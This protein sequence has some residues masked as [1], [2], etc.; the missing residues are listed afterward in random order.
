[1]YVILGFII[2]F[3]AHVSS[4]LEDS[5][6]KTLEVAHSG[7]KLQK[8]RLK[9]AAENLANEDSTG[10]T[11]DEKPY[12]RKVLF[13]KNKYN[14]R[15]NTNVVTIQRYDVSKAPLK[16]RY[17]P[18]HPAADK[19][20]YVAYPNVERAVEL[21]DTEEAHKSYEANLSII[22]VTKSMINKTIDIMK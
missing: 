8:E 9:I 5:L 15:L 22:E 12:G 4:G 11:P 6:L 18:N 3:F 2:I 16:Y 7:M 17:N 19:N 1:M 20:G 21:A 13:A 14:R 10:M